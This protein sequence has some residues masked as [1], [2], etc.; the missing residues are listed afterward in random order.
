MKTVM[1]VSD[2][3]EQALTVFSPQQGCHPWHPLT[4]VAVCVTEAQ[5]GEATAPRMQLQSVSGGT[6]SDG[7]PCAPA[8]N[9]FAEGTPPP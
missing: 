3:Q 1:M 5:G 9:Q 8:P 2:S 7:P 4:W 6:N